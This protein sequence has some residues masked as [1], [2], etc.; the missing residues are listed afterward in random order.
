M[1]TLAGQQLRGDDPANALGP[2][3]VLTKGLGRS[4]LIIGG[5]PQRQR[6]WQI[7]KQ[8][9]GHAVGVSEQ[10]ADPAWRDPHIKEG[11]RQEVISRDAVRLCS[12]KG[13][14]GP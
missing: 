12:P 9:R 1:R 6:R 5:R 2:E 13:V 8:G 14:E 10:S 4:D 11:D 7:R 3:K